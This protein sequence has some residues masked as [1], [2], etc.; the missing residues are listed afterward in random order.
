MIHC[1]PHPHPSPQELPRAQMG[2]HN[3]MSIHHIRALMQLRTGF[4]AHFTDE[5]IKVQRI[6]H[7]LHM[8]V[9]KY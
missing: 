3:L 5:E 4:N 1:A 8:K 9:G 6:W 7:L 2:T